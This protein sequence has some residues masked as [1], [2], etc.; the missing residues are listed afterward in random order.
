[1][2]TANQLLIKLKSERLW[3]EIYGELAKQYPQNRQYALLH[4]TMNDRKERTRLVA[5][6]FVSQFHERP[7]FIAA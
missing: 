6:R 3:S 5:M 1:M 2:S 4:E 7:V